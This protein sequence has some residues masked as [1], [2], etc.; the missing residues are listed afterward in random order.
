MATLRRA[1]AVANER[2]K[3]AEEENARLRALLADAQQ[4]VIIL[5]SDTDDIQQSLTDAID[6]AL[7]KPDAAGGEHD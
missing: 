1:L 2:A 4:M 6:A 3:A 5:G 7:R